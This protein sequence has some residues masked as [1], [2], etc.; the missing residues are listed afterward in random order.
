MI[1]SAEHVSLTTPRDS[2]AR[3]KRFLRIWP[4]VFTRKLHLSSC[5]ESV[6][7]STECEVDPLAAN[8]LS[9]KQRMLP[10]VLDRPRHNKQRPVAKRNGELTV[11]LE[12]AKAEIAAL[13]EGTRRNLWARAVHLLVVGVPA[14]RIL[15]RPIAIHKDRVERSPC[16][17]IHC[18]LDQADDTRRRCPWR[19]IQETAGVLV[20]SVCVTWKSKNLGLNPRRRANGR[21][22]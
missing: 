14:H 11:T 13:A 17:C 6:L 20:R 15:A 21:D 12:V 3:S 10:M 16:L 4:T 19:R 2:C 1:P 5:L 8:T 18:F 9:S 22:Q 7:N